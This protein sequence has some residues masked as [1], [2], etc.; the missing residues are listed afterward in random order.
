MHGCTSTSL[1]RTQFPTAA[2]VV[3]PQA[4]FEVR[5]CGLHGRIGRVNAGRAQQLHRE[6]CCFTNWSIVAAPRAIR[7]LAPENFSAEPFVW[8][9]VALQTQCLGVGSREIAHRL[10]AYRRVRIEQPV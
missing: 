10:P 6:E 1:Q 5:G 8:D 3:P 7:L 4:C 9:A 2:L